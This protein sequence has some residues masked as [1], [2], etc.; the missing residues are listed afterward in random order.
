MISASSV[1]YYP[2]ATFHA[3]SAEALLEM[4]I[5]IFVCDKIKIGFFPWLALFNS[6]YMVFKPDGLLLNTSMSG[7]FNAA[8]IPL[9][10]LPIQIILTISCLASGKNQPIAL[11]FSVIGLYLLRRKLWKTIAVL[12]LCSGLTMY[13]LVPMFGFSDGRLPLWGISSQFFLERVNWIFGAGLG[14]YATIGPELTIEPFGQAFLWL[15]SDWLQIVFETGFLGGLAVLF[16]YTDALKRAYQDEDLFISLST[17]GLFG[18]A[19][20]PLHNPISAVLG[21]VLL[22]SALS[23]T[24]KLLPRSQEIPQRQNRQRVRS[25]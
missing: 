23:K 9:A 11:L 14:T 19:N 2:D 13:F 7:C 17:F 10:P 8:V 22:H 25:S 15:H 21:A 4:M 24:G 18:L 1:I 16:L 5:A 12:V 6:A 3:N 20:F